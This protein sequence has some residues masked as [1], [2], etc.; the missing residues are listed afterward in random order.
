VR[1]LPSRFE[2]RLHPHPAC[3]RP[4]P[5]G[6]AKWR[7]L[8]RVSTGRAEQDCHPG[9][10][11][12]G[13]ACGGG[14][15]SAW[16]GGCRAV[17]AVPA[18]APAYGRRAKPVSHTLS[19]RAG[20]PVKHQPTEVGKANSGTMPGVRVKMASLVTHAVSTLG[21][22]PRRWSSV[23]PAPNAGRCQLP[24]HPARGYG[25]PEAGANRLRPGPEGWVS[26]SRRRSAKASSTGCRDLP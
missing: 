10:R 20:G 5:E 22:T 24:H 14:S 9:L 4:L 12:L 2:T 26:T 3:G 7:R 19:V 11:S 8:F 18:S 25:E 16:P 23:P 17:A 6:E 1:V 15:A 13:C 21:A